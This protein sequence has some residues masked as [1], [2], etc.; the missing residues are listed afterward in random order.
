ML[1]RVACGD[2]PPKPHL[3][4]RQGGALRYEE[5][6]T[7]AGF[8]GPYSILYRE[9]PPQAFERVPPHSVAA[10]LT[11]V[12]E[13]PLARRHYVTTRAVSGG[14]PLSTRVPLLFNEDVVV[15]VLRPTESDP[16]YFVNADGDSLFF[17]RQG[18]GT[19]R[20]GFGDLDFSAGDYLCVPK[21]VLHRFVLGEGPAELFLVE[22]LGGLS[23]PRE[24]RNETG[25][26][27][28]DAP[29]SHRDFGRPKFRGPMDE[30]IR[31]AV[32]KRGGVH[33]GLRWDHSP[34]D[35]VGWDGT[36]YPF[37]FPIL[38]FQPRV[39][40][41]HLPPTVH[42]T[43]AARGALVCSF[44]PRPLDFH[45]DAV[46]C[47]YPHSSVDVDEVLYYVSGDFASRTGIEPGSLTLHPAGVPH[48]PHPG[49]YESSLGARRTEEVAVMIDCHRPLFRT[50]IATALEDTEYDGSFRAPANESSSSRGD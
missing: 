24:F 47:P 28:M 8:D 20:S 46:P 29:Y 16:C 10:P 41:I 35:V 14:P 43:F 45:P 32:V 39:S 1:D 23:V 30:G 27:R 17:V 5:C 25:Q 38:A 4:L 50:A 26:L 3:A 19:L 2:L 34:L 13:N 48:G 6:L 22:C 49:R 18:A 37:T 42:G 12:P 15:S 36:V 21:G 11:A 9:H 33:H 31:E 40:S 7:R 44:V